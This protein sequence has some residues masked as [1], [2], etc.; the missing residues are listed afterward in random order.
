MYNRNEKAGWVLWFVGLGI[1]FYSGI[2]A[3]DPWTVVGSILFML[4]VVAF[5]VPMKK[6][7]PV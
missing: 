1:F 6:T 2:V 7:P 5:L 4:G 3:R